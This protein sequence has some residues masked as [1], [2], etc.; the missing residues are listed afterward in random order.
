M[1]T[2][3]TTTLTGKRRTSHGATP[4]PWTDPAFESRT[5]LVSSSLGHERDLLLSR[6]LT[7]GCDSSR[8]TRHDR[9]PRALDNFPELTDYGV[10]TIAWSEGRARTGPRARTRL[11]VIAAHVGRNFDANPAGRRRTRPQVF[12]RSCDADPAFDDIRGVGKPL[13]TGVPAPNGVRH[14]NA[15]AAGSER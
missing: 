12:G 8:R 11:S 15:E 13:H 1:F 7:I 6:E 9:D 10:M 5:L 3:P 14:E 2:G 4:L